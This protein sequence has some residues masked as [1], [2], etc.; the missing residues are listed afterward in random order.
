MKKWYGGGVFEML[1]LVYTM[2]FL[3]VIQFILGQFNC[4]MFLQNM[5]FKK[6]KNV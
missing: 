2:H 5:H 4:G 1:V 6:K 3:I